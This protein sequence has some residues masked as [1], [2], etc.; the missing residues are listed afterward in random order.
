[1]E[2]I[3]RSDI[4]KVGLRGEVVNVAGPE[5][6]QCAPHAGAFQLEPGAL[7]GPV[8]VIGAREFVALA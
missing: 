8:A 1:M 3:L 2:V 6:S 5:L 7:Q 4:D